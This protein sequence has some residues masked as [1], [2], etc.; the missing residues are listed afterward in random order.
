[1]G[2][3]PRKADGRGVFSTDLKRE[4]VQRIQQELTRQ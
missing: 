1:M 3:L 2:N 4:T